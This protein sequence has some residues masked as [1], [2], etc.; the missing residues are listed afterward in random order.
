MNDNP[1]LHTRYVRNI[2][3]IIRDTKIN[4]SL[5]KKRSTFLYVCN[6]DRE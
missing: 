3:T 5:I 6:G 4:N 2:Y 1:Q